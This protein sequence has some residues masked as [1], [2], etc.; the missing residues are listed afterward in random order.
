MDDDLI[1]KSVLF[2][3]EIKMNGL[4]FKERKDYAKFGKSK[5]CVLTWSRYIEDKYYIVHQT[6]ENE[7]LK[8]ES[9]DTNLDSGDVDNFK[10]KWMDFQIWILS[11]PSS[12]WTSS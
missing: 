2:D 9:V 4:I 12:L 3:H 6:M 7:K 11:R 1:Y 10:E 5:K 8:S